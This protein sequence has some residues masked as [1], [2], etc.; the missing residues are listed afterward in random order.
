MPSRLRKTWH[1]WIH[2][3]IGKHQ[4]H[5]GGHSHAGGMLHHRINFNQYHP[6]YFGTVGSRHY[7]FKSNQKFCPVVH[8][9]KLWTLVSEQLW[10]NSARNRTGVAPIIDV[11]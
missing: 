4:K 1:F 5:S 9:D 2:S 7:H 6:G 8:L 11:I 3:R 10:V